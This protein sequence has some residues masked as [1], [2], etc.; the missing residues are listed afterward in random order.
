MTIFIC[1]LVFRHHFSILRI[2]C[3]SLE[4]LLDECP[5]T[6]GIDGRV[7]WEGISVSIESVRLINIRNKDILLWM[8]IERR[9]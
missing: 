5:E 7:F 4:G 3:V 9:K 1:V 2:N 6:E 8:L